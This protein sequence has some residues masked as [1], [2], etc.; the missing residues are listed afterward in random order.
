[1]TADE[2]TRI[3]EGARMVERGWRADPLRRELSATAIAEGRPLYLVGGAVRDLLLERPVGDWDLAGH[4]IIDFARHFAGEH[5]L[6]VV[7]LHEDFPTARVILRPGNPRGFVDF[8]E[9]RAPTIE[10]DLRARDFTVNALAWDVRGGGALIDP[11][12]GV[13][14]L[15]ARRVRAPERAVLEA[16]PLRTLRAFRFAAELGF[17][18]DLETGAWLRDL[19][20]R[21]W[22]VPGERIGTEVVKLFAA[23]HAA[24]ALQLAE[25]L[26]ALE[27]FFPMLAAMRGVEQ[28]GY[29]HLDVLGHTLLTLHEVERVINEPEAVFPR[30]AGA[31]RAWVSDSGNRAAVRLAALFHDAGKPECRARI[32]GHTRF[33][34]HADAGAHVFAQFAERVALPT[35]LRRQVLRMVRLH[36]RPLELANAG[37][38]AEDEGRPLADAIT[39]RAIRRLMRD[40]EPAG[41]GLLLVA[42]GDRSACRGP[43]SSIEQRARQFAIFDDL[44]LRYLQW[45]CEH[46]ARPRLIS[47]TD[48]MAELG[49]AEGPLVGALLDAINEAWEDREITTR[50]QALALARRLLRERGA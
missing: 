2:P 9:L 31:V 47:G 34:G 33:L 1:M 23:P 38:M 18:I 21:V 25:G 28:G 45:Q 6:R 8:A 19:A 43:A 42:V 48:L 4:G 16:D 14:D 10:A 12:G 13:A 36:M 20:S 30:S 46:H 50:E 26:G 32:E 37:I 40:A 29:H 11:M 7:I 22:E 49:I 15:A 39:I 44:L 24:D 35:H 41:I 27:S 5:D 17:G 3:T